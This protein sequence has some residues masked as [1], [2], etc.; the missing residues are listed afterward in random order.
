MTANDFGK[1]RWVAVLGGVVLFLT[2]AVFYSALGTYAAIEN[3]AILH[4]GH[5]IT[6][7]AEP[8]A[9]WFGV[10]WWAVPGIACAILAFRLAVL[11]FRMHQKG[12]LLIAAKPRVRRGSAPLMDESKTTTIDR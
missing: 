3:G 11:M 1:Y 2:G 6:A 4:R 10:G 12:E 5:E 7:E 9:Y 8:V